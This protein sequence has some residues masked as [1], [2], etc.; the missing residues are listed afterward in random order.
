MYF[1]PPPQLIEAELVSAVPD[2]LRNAPPKVKPGQPRCFLEGPSFDR[3]GNLYVVDIRYG[4]ILRL[5][6]GGQWDAV[7]EYDGEPNGLKIHRDG[8]IF[9]A[10]R[11]RGIVLIDPVRGTAETVLAGPSKSEPFKG[12]NDLIFAA[13]GDLYFT[14]QGRT[15]L[16]DPTGRVY[17]FDLRTDRL[18][19]LI[20]N[21]P[22]PNGLV[23]NVRETALFVA[24]TRGSSVWR[25][26]LSEPG[27]GAAGWP[28]QPIGAASQFTQLYTPGPDGLALDEEGNLVIAHPTA[29]F[30]WVVSKYGVPLFQIRSC[31]KEMTTNIA[32]GG[33]DNKTLFIVESK[34]AS[35]LAARLPVAGKR[36]YSHAD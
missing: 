13:N 20:G 14:D 18:Q 31:A 10:D 34:S 33:A 3:V 15:G 36:M 4:R 22:S 5:A 12:L 27:A 26:P 28:S 30:V 9:V 23:F 32:Y 7:A 2:G 17:R 6:P 35:I 21:V 29:G 16:Q 11:K 8:R 25:I 1:G 19:C 24:A